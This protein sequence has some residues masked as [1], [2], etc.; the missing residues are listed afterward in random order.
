MRLY[1]RIVSTIV[2]PNTFAQVIDQFL[3]RL[4]LRPGWLLTVEISDQADSESNIIQVIT[5]YMTT[6]D[7]PGPAAANLD[8]AVAGGTSV[9]DHKMICQTIPHLSGIAM[10]KIKNLRVPLSRPAVVYNDVAPSAPLHG[11]IVDRLQ[12]GPGKIFVSWTS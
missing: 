6:V 12:N 7:L 11:S 3:H 8:L 10:V 5:V 9:T 4:I 1:D 2:F